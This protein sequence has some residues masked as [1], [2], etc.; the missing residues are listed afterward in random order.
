MKGQAPTTK[1]YQA[2]YVNGAAVQKPWNK[3]MDFQTLGASLDVFHFYPSRK[4][5][6]IKVYLSVSVSYFI[7]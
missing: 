6:K 3:V 5:R 2:K 7:G 4:K 1:N